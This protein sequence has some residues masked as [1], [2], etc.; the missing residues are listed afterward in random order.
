MSTDK[1]ARCFR[2]SKLPRE[3]IADMDYVLHIF[4]LICVFSILA[5]SL[6]LLIGHTGLLSLAHASF[7]GIGAY[8]SA[9]LGTDLN[10][11]FLVSILA[12]SAITAIASLLVSLPSLRL[13]DDYFVISTFGL[14]MILFN[15]FNNWMALTHG[16]LGLTGIPRPIIFGWTITTPLQFSVLALV[17]ATLSYVV[18]FLITQ[19][20]FGRILHAIRED[21]LFAQSMG[22]N[23]IRVKVTV[24]AVSSALAALAGSVYAHYITF[25][26]PPTFSVM[27]SILIISMVIVGGA[28]S[29]WGPLIGAVSLVLLPEVLRFVGLPSPVGAN[30]R[31][32]IYGALLVILMIY[33]PRGLFGRYSLGVRARKS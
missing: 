13:S 23:T 1:T 2:A 17:F 6:D 29:T 28:G 21:E 12:A 24:C 11:P 19:S 22:K 14:Q 18:V 7:Y 31:Q 33:R 5:I 4:I 25:I 9:L 8:T 10:I 16:P 26:D 27:E 20:P 15:V 30:L 3:S 32:I